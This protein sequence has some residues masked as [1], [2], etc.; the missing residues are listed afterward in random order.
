MD[1]SGQ[2]TLA[3][4]LRYTQLGFQGIAKRHQVVHLGDNTILLRGGR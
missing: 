2:Q 1:G 3:V 4:G